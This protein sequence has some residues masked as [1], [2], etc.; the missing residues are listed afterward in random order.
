[1][2]TKSVKGLN[3]IIDANL[4]RAAEGLRVCE[5]LFRYFYDQKTLTREHK[6]LRHKLADRA[7]TMRT[8]A[9]IKAR[10]IERDVGRGSIPKEMNRPRVEDILYA[11]SQRVKES[12]RVLEETAKVRSTDAAEDLKQLRYRFYALEKKAL[13]WLGK[14]R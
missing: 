5:D 14:R 12:L 10:G 1:M 6:T 3:R 4:N 2:S 8:P 7:R 11:N 9:V 13:L